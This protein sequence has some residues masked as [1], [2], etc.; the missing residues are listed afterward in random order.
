[1]ASSTCSG[2]VPVSNESVNRRAGDV[3][4]TG[5]QCALP[6]DLAVAAERAGAH[7]SEGVP[8]FGSRQRQMHRHKALDRSCG[9]RLSPAGGESAEPVS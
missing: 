7:P 4:D 2:W 1:M 3:V 6:M 9:F 5:A 8:A